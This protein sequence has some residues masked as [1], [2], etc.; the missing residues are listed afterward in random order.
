MRLVCQWFR[1][2]VDSNPATAPNLAT[3]FFSQID[4][5]FKRDDRRP[6][7]PHNGLQWA[8]PRNSEVTMYWDQSMTTTTNGVDALW[9]VLSHYMQS[10]SRILLRLWD[11]TICLYTNAGHLSASKQY[12]VL[13]CDAPYVIEPHERRRCFC[14][15]HI[16]P[17]FIRFVKKLI[18]QSGDTVLGCSSPLE[19]YEHSPYMIHV[20]NAIDRMVCGVCSQRISF[21]LT[22]NRHHDAIFSQHRIASPDA[23]D[24]SLC[25]V[26]K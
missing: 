26:V 17:R 9:T 24:I 23:K 25:K 6:Y 3:T 20:I 1:R 12:C 4:A 5:T 18:K 16:T 14:K 22:L 11:Y 19:L 15:T 2:I 10:Q 21:N 7:V 13:L 8:W